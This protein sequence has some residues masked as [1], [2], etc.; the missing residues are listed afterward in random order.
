MYDENGLD[1]LEEEIGISVA[2]PCFL[3]LIGYDEEEECTGRRREP[4]PLDPNF[5]YS[6]LPF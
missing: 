4:T 1:Y 5:D 6:Q 3:D 2:G